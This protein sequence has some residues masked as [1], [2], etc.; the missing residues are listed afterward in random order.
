MEDIF[1]NQFLE[2]TKRKSMPPSGQSQ[3]NPQPSLELPI[4]S[5]TELINLPSPSQIK[6][7]SLDL[8]QAIEK[9]ETLRTY[10]EAELSLD[11]L[12]YLLWVSQ[13]VKSV[14]EKAATK[15]NV[16]SAGSRHA[17]E[18]WLLVN[19][20][21]SLEPG[22]YRYVA[23]THKLIRVPAVQSIRQILTDACL[24]QKHVFESAV[25]FFWVAVVERMT[26]RYPARGY[27]YLFLDAGH[28]C[29]NLYLA[30]EQ[31]GCGVCAIAAYDDDL[32]NQALQVDGKNLFTIY[33]AS[34][35]KR[36]N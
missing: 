21:E 7:P 20:V 9:R 26:W 30:A 13:G 1:G 4:P 32:V 25:T 14:T 15:R 3:G 18:T 36:V 11:E 22:L 19:R 24:H 16:P 5:D 35:G 23:L 17:F 31:I 6:I 2:S 34:L 33:I 8:R 27:R 12:S 28:V 29:Q 10:S